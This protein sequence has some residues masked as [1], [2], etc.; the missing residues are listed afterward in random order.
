MKKIL[1]ILG[2]FLLTCYIAII[3]IMISFL[4]C[5]NEY[6]V[7][8]ILNHSLIIVDDELDPY[9]K[10]DLIIVKQNENS[11][12]E[13]GNNIFF[14]EVTNGVPS[15]NIGEVTDIE[16]ISDEESTFTIN[17]NHVISSENFIG[18]SETA[19]TIHH[20]GTIISIVSSRVGFLVF[21]VLPSLIL[22]LYA[23]Y[24]LI[25]ELKTPLE[26]EE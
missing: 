22:F 21:I 16:V 6:S 13:V 19:T 15:I 20:V 18:K 2:V 25:I 3:I 5:Y 17:N 14:Y 1:K 8:E 11:E 9:T 10:G 23:I 7:T 24:K 26:Q 12:V 4:L